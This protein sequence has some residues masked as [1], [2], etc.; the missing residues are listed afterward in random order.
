MANLRKISKS[1]FLQG[2]NLALRNARSLLREAEFLAKRRA[3]S[4]ASAL[5]VLSLEE[6]GKVIFLTVC[7]H[8]DRFH[9]S[10]KALSR[11][12]KRYR[13]HQ[14]KLH[15]FESWYGRKWRGVLHVRKRKHHDETEESYKRE[16]QP[17]LKAVRKVYT[18]IRS[19]KLHSVAQLKLKCL[20]ADMDEKTHDFLLP[21]KVPA[22][23]VK[24]L[25]LIAKSQIDDVAKLRDTFRRAKTDQISEDIINLMFEPE[26]K[27]RL[28]Q[29]MSRTNGT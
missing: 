25:L 27:E 12:W 1:Q 9:A 16:V 2:M 4:R 28:L 15:F 21:P 5:A 6:S 19:M 22:S 29:E 26:M 20:Y 18:Y 8:G 10:Q 24:G 11:L 14:T 13:D 17:L 23:V 7:S 3:F